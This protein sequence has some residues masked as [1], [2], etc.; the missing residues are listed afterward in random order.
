MSR[1][2]GSTKGQSYPGLSMIKDEATRT[3][4]RLLWDAVNQ[5]RQPGDSQDLGGNVITGSGEPEED[6]DL[7]TKSYVDSVSSPAAIR[8]QLLA[9]GAAALDVTA[10]RGQLSQVQRAKLT[11]I[12]P[13]DPLPPVGQPGELIYQNPTALYYY[14]ASTNVWTVVAQRALVRILPAGPLPATGLNGE[15]AYRAP[16][17]YFYRLSTLS[18]VLIV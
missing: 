2:P 5:L 16:N 8:S 11:V 7:A 12:P 10:L 14:D 17:L 6:T 13:T 18:W 9:T 4:L 3:S 15:L 1:T